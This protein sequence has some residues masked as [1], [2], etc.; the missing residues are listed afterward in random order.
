VF[1]S[2]ITVGGKCPLSLCPSP[3]YLFTLFHLLFAM[4]WGTISD[5]N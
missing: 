3:I 1:V 4:L 5:G 2:D